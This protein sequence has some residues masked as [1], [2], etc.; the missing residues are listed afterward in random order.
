M[1]NEPGALFYAKAGSL[2]VSDPGGSP[3]RK[4]TEGPFDTQPA[5]SPDRSHVAFVRKAN[6]DDYGG[7]LWVLDL[8][9]QIAP[10][11]PPR[12]LVDPAAL[13]HGSG[14]MPP[15]VAV[16]RW[17][18]NGD[19]VAFVDNP[20]GGA[21]AGGVLLVAATD[22]G[23]LAP[24]PRQPA[25]TAWV[26]FAAPDFA[27]AP[28]GRHIAW[29]NQRSDVRPTDVN[30]LTVGGDSSPLVAGTNA[31]SV[32]YAKDGQT[33][34]FGNSSVT[35]DFSPSAR[36]EVRTGGVYSVPA[37]S[38]GGKPPAA[39]LL[40]NRDNSS[41]SDVAA[42]DS[43]ALS[44]TTEGAQDGSKVIQVLDSG[45]SLPRTIVTDVAMPEQGPEWG[46]GDFVAYLNA[47]DETALVVTDVD[48]RNPRQVDTGVDSFAWAR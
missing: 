38:V 36:F 34:L 35:A 16:P 20:T 40:L 41:F 43:G 18:P 1:L 14:G 7:D 5:P 11:G 23:V 12:R 26:P 17:S 42:L 2:Y 19:Q 47:S 25:E 48:N 32:A 37:V 39:T 27:W 30:V 10:A 4:L 22:T 45:S 44:F 3:G 24:R 15:M 6:A 28:D 8:T 31:F 29:M 13:V 21:V 33:I 9:P 46:R